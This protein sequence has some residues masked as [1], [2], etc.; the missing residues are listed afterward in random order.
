MLYSH[1]SVAVFTCLVKCFPAIVG[2]SDFVY[3]KIFGMPTELTSY[4]VSTFFFRKV[5]EVSKM[6]IFACSVVQKWCSQSVRLFSSLPP[7]FEPFP[8]F[9]F[10]GLA[11]L[12]HRFKPLKKTM[13]FFGFNEFR[14]FIFN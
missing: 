9:R 13:F 8:I 7:I 3:G 14:C 2:C 5:T 10:A 12:N 11:G 6:A 1:S 4:S